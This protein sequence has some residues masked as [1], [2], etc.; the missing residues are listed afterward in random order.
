MTGKTTEEMEKP[1]KKWEVAALSGKMENQESLIKNVAEKLDKLDAK[2][3]TRHDLEEKL[4]DFKEQ[5]NSEIQK[6]HLKYDPIAKNASKLG[7][8]LVSAGIVLVTQ[9]VI[10]VLQ[11]V[12]FK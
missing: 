10:L 11:I 1:A 12:I 4:L 8:A 5:L 6:V 2:Q 7:W 3:I 9:V